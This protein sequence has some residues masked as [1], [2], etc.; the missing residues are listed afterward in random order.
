MYATPYVTKS[1]DPSV[2]NHFFR[3]LELK[4][5]QITPSAPAQLLNCPCPPARDGCCHISGLVREMRDRRT[6]GQSLS[7]RI[8]DPNRKP[9]RKVVRAYASPYHDQIHPMRRIIAYLLYSVL[10][11]IRFR[12]LT[13]FRHLLLLLP[14]TRTTKVW[15]YATS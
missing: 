3:R 7:Q 2:R 4:G 11:Q 6:D 10:T 9:S 12:I 13:R 5:D 14:K 1:V 8:A 15:R